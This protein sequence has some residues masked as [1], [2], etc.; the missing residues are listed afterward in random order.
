MLGRR[1]TR[2]RG[3]EVSTA[4]HRQNR[5]LTESVKSR[6]TAGAIGGLFF[7][8]FG[9]L[10][11]AVR[12]GLAIVSG[13][14]FHFGASDA[15]LLI[16][17]PV[18]F[19]IAGAVVGALYPMRR[20]WIGAILLGIIGAAVFFATVLVAAKGSP[21]SWTHKEWLVLA[22]CALTLGTIAGIQFRKDR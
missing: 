3:A 1:V 4:F 9:L 15:L 8:A 13:R 11:G 12:I 10:I 20:Y 19:V 21:I 16:S 5:P 6:V 2:L 14:R 18:G 22:L 17:Y 7:A